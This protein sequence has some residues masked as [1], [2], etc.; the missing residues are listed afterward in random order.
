MKRSQPSFFLVKSCSEFADARSPPFRRLVTLPLLRMM[1]DCLQPLPS[2]SMSSRR[3]ISLPLHPGVTRSFFKV[4]PCLKHLDALLS[5]SWVPSLGFP[6]SPFQVLFSPT[7]NGQIE[8]VCTFPSPFLVLPDPFMG[9][10]YFVGSLFFLFFLPPVVFC[11]S[12][13]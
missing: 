3:D 13:C 11:F 1:R 6:I 12:L 8:L 4:A 5:T 2:D 10:R 9:F 7:P